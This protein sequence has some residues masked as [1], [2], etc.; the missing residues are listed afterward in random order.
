MHFS[1]LYDYYL[2]TPNIQNLNETF[3]LWSNEDYQFFLTRSGFISNDEFN[4]KIVEQ[5]AQNLIDFN[6][7]LAD[8]YQ[9]NLPKELFTQ[10]EF[11]WALTLVNQKAYEFSHKEFCQLNEFDPNTWKRELPNMKLSDEIR[12]KTSKDGFALIPYFDL[13]AEEK[14]E[15][16]LPREVELKHD[17]SD[18]QKL[19]LDSKILKVHLDSF[20]E[21]I[22]FDLFLESI[23]PRN[24]KDFWVIDQKNLRLKANRRYE[25][26]EEIKYFKGFK[27]NAKRLKDFGYILDDNF[28]SG[29][30]IPMIWSKFNA[31]E[32]NFMHSI[33]L[34]TYQEIFVTNRTVLNFHHYQICHKY[35]HFLR[36]FIMKVEELMPVFNETKHLEIIQRGRFKNAYLEMLVWYNYIISLDSREMFGTNIVEDREDLQKEITK[37]NWLRVMMLEGAIQEKFVIYK[38]LF[39]AWSKWAKLFHYDINQGFVKKAILNAILDPSAM[40]FYTERD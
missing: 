36:V 5:Q 14:V 39:G 18:I 7:P 11:F 40:Y 6:L 15:L 33:G 26:G 22:G 2:R 29:V 28:F 21:Q 35:V 34:G 20:T 17:L 37:G 12:A 19:G 31:N 25:P 24:F 4:R 3:L 38:H 27:S 23:V 32:K 13:I 1:F 16:G 8:K 10:S 9:P 30:S